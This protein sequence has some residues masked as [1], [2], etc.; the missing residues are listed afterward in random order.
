M[1]DTPRVIALTGVSGGLGRALLEAFDT[2]GHRVFGCARSAGVVRQ[3]QEE[4]DSRHRFDT[5]DV[6]DNE[7]VSRWAEDVLEAAGAP[8]L[9]INNAALMN[10]SLPLW[11]VPAEE[12]DQLMR[13]NVGGTANVLRAFL[14]AMIERGTGV[15]VNL[16]SGWGRS[17]SPNVAP[18]CASKFAIEG[19]SQAVAQ[20]VPRGLAV[21]ALNPGIINTPM[22]QKCW[23]EGA[24]AYPDAQEWARVAAPYLLGLTAKD[25]GRS[26][27]VT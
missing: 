18:Y 22:L 10:A 21:V 7:A 16:S 12:F 8:D 2:A 6:A 23:A 3:L 14:P 13:V 5:V 19:L 17:T 4:K 27:S 25:N 24:D 11:E 9:L 20:E 1:P 15:A 26:L